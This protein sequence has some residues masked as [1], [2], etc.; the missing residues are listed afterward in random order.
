MDDKEIKIILENART[1]AMIG[2]RAEK[3][4]DEPMTIKRKPAN[5]VRE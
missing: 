4:K 3:K 2:I 5:V 1:I